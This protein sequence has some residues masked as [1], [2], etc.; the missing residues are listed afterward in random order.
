MK[1]EMMVPVDV[2]EGQARAPEGFELGL[3]FGIH[4]RP[5][6]RT[7]KDFGTFTEQ[8]A[9]EQAVGFK[10]VRNI[11]DRRKRLAVDKNQMK[12]DT[13]FRHAAG[14]VHGIFR[15]GRADHQA[16]GSKDSTSVRFF[17]RFIDGNGKAEII[18]RDD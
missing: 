12:T 11:F 1:M 13:E 5:R 4:L 9:R 18:G 6:L 17:N 2:I 14:A 16:R 3:D 7:K 8:V 10:Q 15:G